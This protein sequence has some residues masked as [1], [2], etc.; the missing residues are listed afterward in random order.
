MNRYIWDGRVQAAGINPYRYVPAASEVAHLRDQQIYP[1]INRKDY[2]FTPYPPVAQAIYLLVYLAEP[3]SITAFKVAM[4]LF[5]IITMIVIAL[6][7]SR[8]GLEAS[9]TIVFAWNPLLIFEGAHSG[10]IE[11][12]F[13]VFL[14]LALLAWTYK[15]STLV[16]VAIGLATLVKFYPIL[17]LPAFLSGVRQ[18]TLPETRSE[19]RAVGAWLGR[20]FDLLSSV[21]FSRSNLLLLTGFFVTIVACYLPYLSVGS[22][23]IRPLVSELGEEGFTDDGSRYFLLSLTRSVL[24]LP[25][26]VFLIIAALALAALALRWLLS[27]KRDALDVACGSLGLIGL[28]LLITSPRYPWHYAWMIP[29]LCFV[30]R[31]G[32]FFMTGATVLLYLLWFTP[33]QYP[34]L[35]Q[36][37]GASIF[38]PTIGFLAW[39]RLRRK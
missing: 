38:I 27:E 3:S 8:V 16:G 26:T 4:S 15:R 24:P 1:G 23:V 17:L 18:P 13:M 5:D 22:A 33:W 30:P 32:W 12:A 25:T 10:H 11:S 2:V 31:V 36:W 28:D 7:L 39:E 6:V 20:Q 37:L 29:F 21:L 34:E 9:R 14:A 35:P 19:R